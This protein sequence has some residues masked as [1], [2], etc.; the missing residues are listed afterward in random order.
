LDR[1]VWTL[2]IG[3]LVFN[4]PAALETVVPALPTQKF[5]K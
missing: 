3:L 1:N 4:S 5:A 2:L